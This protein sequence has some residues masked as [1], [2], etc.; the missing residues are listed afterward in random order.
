[1]ADYGFA[2]GAEQEVKKKNKFITGLREFFR[3]RGVNL[4]ADPDIT[5]IQRFVEH[6]STSGSVTRPV[7]ALYVGAHANDRAQLKVDLDD[8]RP[9]PM[10]QYADEL[11]RAV[12]SGSL[13]IPAGVTGAS[14]SFRIRGCKIGQ[15]PRFLELL[16]QALGG[17]LPVIAPKLYDY[18]DFDTTLGAFE[19][20]LYDFEFIQQARATRAEVLAAYRA[21]GETFIDGTTAVPADSWEKW[22]PP[23][24]WNGWERTTK[25]MAKWEK[26]GENQVPLGAEIGGRK[27]WDAP[28]EFRHI[29]EDWE[30][31]L[32]PGTQV[33]GSAA[34]L[35]QFMLDGLQDD[36]RFAGAHLFPV[37]KRYDFATNEQWVDA[38]AWTVRRNKKKKPEALAGIRH[39][40][41]ASPPVLNPANGTLTF[42]FE[43]VTGS[44]APRTTRVQESNT[45]FFASV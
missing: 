26:P 24:E 40:Y 20:F 41:S 9:G 14:S 15:S 16:K 36:P 11:V 42:N 37:P 45:A 13:T 29:V 17:S 4:P 8:G 25:G 22:L 6:V 12:G 18:V 31:A 2:P 33:P 23:A 3:N 44:T 27:T 34:G 35:R 28:I 10:D 1:M 5:N 19:W 32:A 39:V 30:F 21:A 38:F 7:G 43:P